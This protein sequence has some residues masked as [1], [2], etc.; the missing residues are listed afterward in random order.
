MDFVFDWF[1]GDG[2]GS[3]LDP[4]LHTGFENAGVFLCHGR[5]YLSGRNVR[6]LMVVSP[7]SQKKSSALAGGVDWLADGGSLPS[8]PGQ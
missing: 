3:G 2:H 4:R 6:R 7:Q 5:F 8:H 1:C